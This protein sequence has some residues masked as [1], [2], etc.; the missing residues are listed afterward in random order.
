MERKFYNIKGVEE[1]CSV[2][3]MFNVLPKE[4]TDIREYDNLDLKQHVLNICGKHVVTPRLQT[5]FGDEGTY[6]S[7]SGAVARAHTWTPF[8]TKVKEYIE[9]VTELTFNFV[10]INKYRDGNDSIGWHSD[11]EKEL[12]GPIVSV[13]IGCVRD[14]VLKNNS[15]KKSI[16]IPLPHNSCLIFNEKTNKKYKHS[17]PVRKKCTSVRYNLTFRTIVN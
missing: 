13:T 4:L 5:A 15:T 8:L 1:G 17:V 14:F 11:G 6:Y 10:L 9:Q 16:T 12:R 7:F 2:R 3:I